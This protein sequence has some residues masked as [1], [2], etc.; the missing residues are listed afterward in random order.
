MPD[1]MADPFFGSGIVNV[2]AAEENDDGDDPKFVVAPYSATGPGVTLVAPSF[3]QL[4]GHQQCEAPEL[5]RKRPVPAPDIL[6]HGGYADDPDALWSGGKGST[7]G[8]GGTSAASA[9][10]AGIAARVA[11]NHQVL[12]PFCWA[13]R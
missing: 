8:F 11:E 2:G 1:D 13:C 10:V 9:Q 7:F 3:G 4:H 5:S 12:L 6:G